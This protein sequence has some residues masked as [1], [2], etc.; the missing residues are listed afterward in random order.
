MDSTIDYEFRTTIVPT[1]LELKDL[2]DIAHALKG[3]KLFAIQQF[4]PNNTLSKKLRGV[5]PFSKEELESIL[6][7]IK[8]KFDTVTIRGLK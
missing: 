8:S 1:L 2:N 6:E 7:Q 4:V 3:A 5:K